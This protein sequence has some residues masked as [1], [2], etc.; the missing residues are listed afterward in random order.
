MILD[1]L[2]VPEITP[3]CSRVQQNAKIRWKLRICKGKGPFGKPT[4]KWQT[5]FHCSWVQS[6]HGIPLRVLPPVASS[7]RFLPSQKTPLNHAATKGNLLD[8]DRKTL[9]ELDFIEKGLCPMTANIFRPNRI[10]EPVQR[11]QPSGT[12]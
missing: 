5:G 2:V 4:I 3:T 10:G 8:L 6:L 12:N 1:L 11:R 9:Y 7:N